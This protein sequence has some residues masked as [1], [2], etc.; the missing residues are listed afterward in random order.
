MAN[1]KLECSGE[2][3]PV[4]TTCEVNTK[5]HNLKLIDLPDTSKI[6]AC[7]VFLQLADAALIAVLSSSCGLPTRYTFP[8][9]LTVLN[10]SSRYLRSGYRGTNELPGYWCPMVRTVRTK[11][12][13]SPVTGTWLSVH[14]RLPILL[15]RQSLL[16]A[17]SCA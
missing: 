9:H 17:M 5:R 15:N 2:G 16:L 12:G 13:T 10:R 11:K 6:G 4:R 7:L 1:V 14:P 8:D 3:L